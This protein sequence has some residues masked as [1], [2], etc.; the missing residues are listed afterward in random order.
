VLLLQPPKDDKYHSGEKEEEKED[1]LEF[2]GINQFVQVSPEGQVASEDGVVVDDE[3]ARKKLLDTISFS[4]T[5]E[6]VVIAGEPVTGETNTFAVRHKKHGIVKLYS[7]AVR[8]DEDT[9]FKIND[10]QVQRIDDNKVLVQIANQL[11][12]EIIQITTDNSAYREVLDEFKTSTASI[13][14]SRM[15]DGTKILTPVEITAVRRALSNGKKPTDIL[16]E[17]ANN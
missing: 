15:F 14:T 6:L 11:V 2:F 4:E 5:K 12:V 13:E 8:K 7:V 1:I 16:E 9:V 17:L 10:V 3:S